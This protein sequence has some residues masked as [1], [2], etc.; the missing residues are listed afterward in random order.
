MLFVS[1]V[2]FTSLVLFI[3]SL[4]FYQVTQYLFW[5]KVGTATFVHVLVVH[6]IYNINSVYLLEHSLL[7]IFGILY[8]M[9]EAKREQTICIELKVKMISVLIMDMCAY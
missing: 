8:N 4:E 9:P 3:S 5:A 6:L 1:R 2:L 7:K